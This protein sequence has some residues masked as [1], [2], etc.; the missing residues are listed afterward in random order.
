MRRSSLLALGL[1]FAA[2]LSTIALVR[3]ADTASA[4]AALRYPATATVEQVD[5][6]H[7]VAVRDPYR[8]L[9]ED[10][11]ESPRVQ[12]WV[13][14]ENKV[15]FDYLAAIPERP[16]INAR[17]HQLY[18]FEKYDVPFE[19]G[20]RYFYRHNDG[21]QNQW[22]VFVQDS[23]T[24]PA[25]VLVDPNTW[26]QDGTVALDSYV[27]SPDGRWVALMVQDGGSD[28]RKV[29]VLELPSG[30][31]LDDEI[32]WVKFSPLAWR[33]DGSGF[34]YSRYP[35]PKEGAEFQSLNKNHT[36]YFHRVGTPQSADVVA[37]ARPDQPDWGLAPAVSED[38]RYLVVTIWLGTDERFQIAV[39]DLAKEDGKPE[40][41]ISGFDYAYD[42]LGNQGSELFFRTTKDA[43][44]GRLIAIDLA[45]PEPAQWR[46]VVAQ[47]AD[48]VES[49]SLVGNRLVA[50]YLKDARSE[51]KVYSLAGALE[52]TVEL[53]GI[54]TAGGFG[55]H[56]DDPETFY[57]YSS[58]T[59]P[60]TIY[61]F[62]VA[63]G[64]STAFKQAKVAFDPARYTVEQVFYRS[65]DGTRVPMFLAHRKD[66]TPNGDRPTLLYGYGGFNLPT[67]PTFSPTRLG[68]MEMGGLYAVA[69]LRG[70]GEYG[71]EWH[72][73]GT[74]LHKQNVFD[75]FIAAAEHLVA[76]GWTKPSRLAV[77]GGSNGGLLVGAV[78]NQRP[79]LFGAAL[80]AVGVMEMLR[81][82]QFTA[83]RFWVDDYGSA[84]DAQEF[85]ALYAYSPYHNLK[86][87]TRY[88]A[89]LATTADHDDR[90]VPLHTF[91]YMA[92]L[93]A[94][95]S[96]PAPVLV[97]IETR[98]GHGSGK[99]TDKILAEV[100]D[101]WAF[102]VKNLGITLPSDYP[103]K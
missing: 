94:A 4:P 71:E 29:R 34:Y 60:P 17:L 22:V 55:G 46:E 37:Y 68:W 87:G 16:R 7:G 49:A 89:I 59:T 101:Q 48:V 77:L 31:Q 12:Q 92:A 2:A 63:T 28:W 9:E 75:D 84:D 53:P 33:R 57:S 73:A 38:G 91:K 24:A 95:Q 19:E 15:T 41:L 51:V 36:V 23:L 93:Q 98:A 21:L 83:G 90:V 5:T 64:A 88:P 11:R 6:Y 10:V 43:P 69:N 79:D 26:S 99:P 97:R 86:P 65:K 27:P 42:F 70:G 62:D 3:A 25:R 52:R 102:L 82:H 78:V 67:R 18:D 96:G 30:K 56:A 74:K 32:A 35:E 66:V 80:P 8:W 85:Q 76:A 81:F 58:F 40:M 45:H 54:G 39:Q 103:A 72:K 1:A 50:R 13:D 14:A 47:G 44:R 100:G 61:R 20:G